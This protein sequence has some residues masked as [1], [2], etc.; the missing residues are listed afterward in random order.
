MFGPASPLLLLCQL[1]RLEF[2]QGKEPTHAKL[3]PIRSVALVQLMLNPGE[4]SFSPRHHSL[5][6][7]PL[8]I[9]FRFGF[10]NNLSQFGASLGRCLVKQLPQLIFPLP[11]GRFQLGGPTSKFLQFSVSCRGKGCLCFFVLAS[12]N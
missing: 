2:L 6:G 3:S 12:A 10:S 7:G 9:E 11:E 1:R 8:G 4:L 5:E